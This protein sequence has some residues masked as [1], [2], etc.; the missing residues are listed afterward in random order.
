MGLL[1][2]LH[3]PYL[4]SQVLHRSV[5]RAHNIEMFNF[6]RLIRKRL[7]AGIL[8]FIISAKFVLVH[9]DILLVETLIRK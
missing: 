4:S 9:S 7:L 6:N 8:S 5:T 2:L 3:E 1:L